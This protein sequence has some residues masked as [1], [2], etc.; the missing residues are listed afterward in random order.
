MLEKEFRKNKLSLSQFLKNGRLEEV[1]KEFSLRN[2]DDLVATIGYGKISAKQIVGKILP[3]EEAHDEKQDEFETVV[4]KTK[5]H[6]SQTAITVKGLHDVLVRLGKCCNP[7][8]G[9]HIAGFIT[10]GRGVTVHSY[11]CP[12]IASSDPE[13]LVEV[14]W[15]RSED[16]VHPARLKLVC[17][18]KQGLLASITNVL[19][20]GE[21]NI[22]K[23]RVDRSEDQKAVLDFTIE[24]QG[25]KHLDKVINSLKRIKEV[26]GIERVR[27]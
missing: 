13:R 21:T 8:P 15:D 11:K 1:A 12:V 14:S 23:A 24:V 19:S 3:R 2:V 5:R 7:L 25:R 22:V 18:D 4:R 27:V 10:R 6:G 9:D 16:G 26:I 20:S 17:E